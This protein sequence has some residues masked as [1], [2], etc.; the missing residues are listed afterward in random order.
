MSTWQEEMRV[1]GKTS[2]AIGGASIGFG[3]REW[4]VENYD[5]LG[6]R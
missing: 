6:W 1:P 3:G 5:L 2:L 4:I